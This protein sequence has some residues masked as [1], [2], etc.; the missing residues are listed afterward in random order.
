MQKQWQNKTNAKVRN[1]C[2]CSFIP[3]NV[4]EN[5]ARNGIIESVNSING[6][7]ISREK[8]EQ[9]VNNM[10]ELTSTDSGEK[11]ARMVYDCK[12]KWE[13]RVKLV[14]Q[15]GGTSPTDDSVKNAYDFSGKVRDY[16]MQKHQRKSIDNANM[17][18]ILNVHYGVKYQNAF[19]DGDEMTFGDGDGQIFTDFSK[20]LD[21]IAHELT[22]GVTQWT[23]NLEYEGQSG[24][25]NEHFSDVFGTVITQYA[26]G[27]TAASADWL[28]GDEI[29]GPQL[30][31]EALRSMS[32]PGTAYDNDLM[33]KDD[34]PSHMKDYYNGSEDNHGVHTNSG[35]LNKAFYLAAKEMEIGTENAGLIWYDSLQKLWPT[36]QFNDAVKVIVDSAKDLT[37]K[38]KIP[39]GAPQKI[40]TA[41]K[42]VGLPQ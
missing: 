39:K 5:L 33:G 10:A 40:R 25:L 8:R 11:A 30:G 9:R 35:I 13:Q 26:E 14:L 28:I 1:R 15:E 24:A 23:A 38:K 12:N 29:M 6:S 27:Q 31:G 2:F 36:A 16:F 18:L 21:V 17:D 20:S 32:E 19:W 3:I 42:E 4:L 41:F 37:N 22:H 34:Q 7:K